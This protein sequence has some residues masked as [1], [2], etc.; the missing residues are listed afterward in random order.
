VDG[1]V[2]ATARHDRK[3]VALNKPSITIGRHPTND[4]VVQDP[5]VSQ[6]HAKIE[7]GPDGLELHD[8]ASHNGT[9]VDGL[10]VR[11]A[12]LSVGSQ[13]GVGSARL[14]VTD[15]HLEH[16]DERGAMSLTCRELTLVA[17][18][19]KIL[20]NATVDVRPGEFVAVIGESG[21]GKSTLIKALVGVTPTP[22]G[23]IRVNGEPLAG[24]LT[25]IGYV[26]QDDIV[27]RNLTV[28]E[29]LNYSARLR[30][31]D[32]STAEE[33]SAAVERVLDEL[34]LRDQAE[35]MIGRLSGGQRKRVG[36][37]SEL[38]SH[39]SLLFL[40]E[41]TSGLDPGLETKLMT[42]FRELAAPGVRAVVVVTH[43]TKNLRQADK[44]CVMGR[45]G[46]LCFVGAPDRALE[47]FG[48]EDFDEIYDALDRRPAMEWRRVF[49]QTRAP[50]S[51]REEGQPAVHAPQPR[52]RSAIRQGR[53]LAARYAR[54]MVRDRRN[55]LILI[56]QVPVIAVLMSLIFQRG[57]LAPP[58][59]GRPDEAVDLLFLLLTNAI[60][61]GAV[62]ASREL[63]KEKP[64][65]MREAAIGVKPRAYLFSK[66]VVLFALVTVQT[67]ILALIV[68]AI[69][70]PDVGLVQHL[71]VLLVLVL[72]GCVAVAMGLGVS[73]LVTTEDQATS[74]TTLALIPQLLFAGA[75]VTIK[76][77]WA[78]AAAVSNVIFSRWSLSGIGH[79]LDM[80]S[81]IAGDPVFARL[82]FY[83]HSFFAVRVLVCCLLLCGFLALMLL[84]VRLALGR[85]AA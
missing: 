63:I 49:D 29:A 56:G 43:A 58:G 21:S 32:D 81:R 26:P 37:A 77:M 12:S 74:F 57:V 51:S 14:T 42:L 67:V 10:H 31:P 54:L 33:L 28:R 25:D 40:D 7:A 78:P 1:S 53:I 64:L 4:V 52:R 34:S 72:T 83:S 16:Q 13:I 79:A 44:V 27:H 66:V 59:R 61:F 85:R 60:F 82:G 18:K 15:A 75:I 8:L 84:A 76:H 11:R 5:N 80:N 22:P 69:Q 70:P 39:P 55:L 30:L 62:D 48:V 38:L 35:T 20:D 71:D 73:A 68:L 9:R 65:A 41:P 50:A 46:E 24:R 19:K 2:E 36:V 6:F 47:F 17:G 3:R 23:V 45:G